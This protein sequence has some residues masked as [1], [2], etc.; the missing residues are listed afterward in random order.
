MDHANK[1]VSRQQNQDEEVG[2]PDLNQKNAGIEIPS[3][4][5]QLSEAFLRLVPAG[6][7]GIFLKSGWFIL[8]CCLL[9]LAVVVGVKIALVLLS[10]QPLFYFGSVLK[11]FPEYSVG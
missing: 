9:P 10:L 3:G 2:V 4:V 1:E 11:G 8:F 7:Y 5:S 6:E